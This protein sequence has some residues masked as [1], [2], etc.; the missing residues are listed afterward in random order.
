MKSFIND[1]MTALVIGAFL[2]MIAILFYIFDP[3]V[4]M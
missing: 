4:K 1:L 3:T 2:F